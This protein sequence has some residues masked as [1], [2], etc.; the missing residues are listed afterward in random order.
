LHALKRMPPAPEFLDDEGK[1]AWSREGRRLIRA[2]LLSE[3]DLSMFGTW[4]IFWSKRDE[5]SRALNKTAVVV[6][7]G[8]VGNPYINPYMSVIAMCSKAMHQI[9]VEFG[10]SPAS[11]SKV[12]SLNPNQRNLFADFLDDKDEEFGS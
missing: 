3:L 6:R 2:G 4:C 7:A 9:E 1:R 12:K 11:R 5:A 8:G 10:L